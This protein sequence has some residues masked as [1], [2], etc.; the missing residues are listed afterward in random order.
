MFFFLISQAQINQKNAKKSKNHKKLQHSHCSKKFIK[1]DESKVLLLK[2]KI[3]SLNAKKIG[4]KNDD[5]ENK[6]NDQDL[7]SDLYSTSSDEDEEEEE[8]EEQ[9]TVTLFE[10]SLKLNDRL[11]DLYGKEFHKNILRDEVLAI[12]FVGRRS[13]DLHTIV[14]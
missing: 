10:V 12:C 3:Q 7:D 11:E 6:K 8:E 4:S 1:F 2:K 5:Q 14:D 13:L 9:E